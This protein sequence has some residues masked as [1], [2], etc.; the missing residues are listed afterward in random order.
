MRGG[1]TVI[2]VVTLLTDF[3][4]ADPY[5]AEMRAR[6]YAEWSRFPAPDPLPVV[7]DL[8]H[9]VPMGDVAA[10]AW[11][12]AR[13]APG[14]PAGAVHLAVVDPGVGTER[15]AVAVAARGQLWV[16][17]GNGLFE[18][19]RRDGADVEVVHLDNP[20]YLRGPGGRPASTFH[21]RDVF[22]PAAA[23][24]AM[25]VPLAQVGSPAPAAALG[26]LAEAGA[27][28]SGPQA[29]RIG[30]VVWIDRFGN[31]LTDVRRDGPHGE[32]LAG[33]AAIALGAARA[34]GPVQTYAR[35]A[36]AAPFWY[37]GSGD[38]LEVALRGR[39]A[40]RE[41]GWKVGLAV[42]IATP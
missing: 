8:S 30:Q 20:L 13:T 33:G 22:A 42:R 25:G 36:T 18:F 1:G 12:L 24:L 2:R 4:L 7:V 27:A 19:L 40:A 34:L 11:L 38:T 32:R 3:G 39:D 5:V 35:G 29:E 21:G 23:H 10:A 15:P 6:L 28:E 26:R 17:P 41:Y 37:W 14:F 16:G 31:A 9:G